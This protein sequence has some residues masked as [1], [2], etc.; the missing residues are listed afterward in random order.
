MAGDND[1]NEF[2]LYSDNVVVD[3]EQVYNNFISSIDEVRSRYITPD[4]VNLTILNSETINRI[5][6]G[7]N[8]VNSNNI[9]QESRCNAFY[10][11]LGLPIFSSKGMYNPG[12][13]PDQSSDVVTERR[14][15]VAN[16]LLSINPLQL[17]F[18]ERERFPKSQLEIF[19]K[20]DEA[21]S[22]LAYSVKYIRPISTLIEENDPLAVEAQSFP[23][24]KR[25]NDQHQT[26]NFIYSGANMAHILKPF[27]PDPRT[28][29]LIFPARNRI[30]VPFLPIK[31]RK[32]VTRGN[33]VA[34]TYKVPLLEVVARVRLAARNKDSD[35]PDLVKIVDQIKK[36]N[37]NTKDKRLIELAGGITKY[38]RSDVFI[39][40]NIQKFFKVMVDALFDAIQVIDSVESKIYW[41]PVPNRLGMEV[42]VT[43]SEFVP[44]NEVGMDMDREIDRLTDLQAIAENEI[45]VL[46]DDL[47]ATDGSSGFNFIND[48]TFGSVMNN[49]PTG[50]TERI[51]TLKT[52]REQLSNKANKA[53]RTIAV[54]LGDTSGL[55]LID[56]YAIYAALW[57]LDKTSLVNMFDD[58][59]ML[60]IKEIPALQS[61]E[62]VLRLKGASQDPLFT[63]TK[64]QTKV[65]EMFN[66]IDALIKAKTS[67]G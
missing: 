35:A 44:Q 26:E 50:I 4:Q 48:L 32:L 7:D 16:A 55:G 27:M 30:A 34:T 46:K 42:G 37:G 67:N 10:R 61:R 31:N 24:K 57:T 62:V 14:Y 49:V 53:L 28:D 1:D 22:K 25:V 33:G 36:D 51:N 29:F 45:N 43:S 20:Q 58:D 47:G 19:A 38:Y 17:K 6:Q 9:P 2:D 66:I 41:A 52:T 3:I 18:T 56:M 40:T 23:F 21:A 54:L 15:S 65:R 63:A 11:R 13:R 39:F 12:Y 60:R 8:K 5:V 59:A 64:F